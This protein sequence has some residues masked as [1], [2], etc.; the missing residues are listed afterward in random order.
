[1]I[2]TSMIIH[3]RFPSR[4]HIGEWRKDTLSS[5]PDA[6]VISSVFVCTY[7]EP[8][9]DIIKEFAFYPQYFFRELNRRSTFLGGYSI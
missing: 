5:L 4:K 1:M 9:R 6:M 7:K 3:T 8:C 2:H